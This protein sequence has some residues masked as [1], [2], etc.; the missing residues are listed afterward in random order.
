M[1]RI[2]EFQGEREREKFL[3]SK[4]CKN[5]NRRRFKEIEDVPLAA[6]KN[7][8]QR[9][10]L[11]NHAPSIPPKLLGADLNWRKDD[12]RV[13]RVLSGPVSP[14]VPSISQIICAA[15][16]LLEWGR[17]YVIEPSMAVVGIL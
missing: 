4:A 11:Y 6:Y 14:R 17:S 13:F 3:F 1:L 16:W 5:L 2:F 8:A 10:F 15:K 12:R 9:N 7:S